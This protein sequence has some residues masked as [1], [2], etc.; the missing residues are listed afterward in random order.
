M[1]GEKRRRRSLTV[2]AISAAVAVAALVALVLLLATQG[3]SFRSTDDLSAGELIF[4]TGTDPSGEPIGTIGGLGGMMVDRG[5][6]GCHGSDG[7]GRATHM[8]TAPDIT[9]GNFTDP[10]GML[11]P[12]GTRHETFTDEDIKRAVIDGLDPDG[13]E[14]DWIMPRWQLSDGQWR[15]L[16][17]YLKTL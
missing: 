12:D 5:C 16:L 11:E 3:P 10:R 9:Y 8:F 4:R 1:N 2:A 7:R 17:D 6:A 15:E 13:E 14:L